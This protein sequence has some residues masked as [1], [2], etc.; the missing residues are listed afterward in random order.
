MVQ[1]A[2]TSSFGTDTPQST[3]CY[4][5]PTT[6]WSTACSRTLTT[7]VSPADVPPEPGRCFFT[8]WH[9]SHFLLCFSSGFFRDRLW[10]QDLVATGSIAVFQQSPRW[11]GRVNP[12]KRKEKKTKPTVKPFFFSSRQGHHSEWADV[13]GNEK[14][15][16]S[17]G[18]F[19]ASN[20]GLPQP[21][22]IRYTHTRAC[23]TLFLL[24]QSQPLFNICL[25]LFAD[26][27]EGDRSEGS[28]QEN[29]DEQ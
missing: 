3:S 17:P 28:G 11:G 2:A 5:K 16:H 27:V 1:T 23:S 15:D 22:Q 9:C 26:R 10:Y 7:P 25:F 19:H 29:E 13:G 20:V 6:T 18:L 4:L 12:Q 21:H 24:D 8:C 14:H